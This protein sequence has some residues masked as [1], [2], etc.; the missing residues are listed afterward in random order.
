MKDNTISG[1][2]N[3]G[4]YSL[5]A[6]ETT[7]RNLSVAVARRQSGTG[8]CGEQESLVA[9]KRSNEA[10]RS[11]GGIHIDGSL[12]EIKHSGG[13]IYIS[14]RKS[15]G[16]L[17]HLTGLIPMI[18]DLLSAEGIA[19][20]SLDA[21]AVSSGPG[22]FT[23]IR[24]GVSATRALAQVLGL[25][26]IK[27]PTL[28]TFVYSFDGAPLVCPVFDARRSQV[29]AG[30]FR[31][32]LGGTSIE[33]I[34]PGGVFPPNEYFGRLE[35]K[36][37]DLGEDLIFCGD[38]ISVYDE[39]VRAAHGIVTNELQSARAVAGWAM[40]FGEVMNFSELEPIYM[41]KAEAQRKLEERLGLSERADV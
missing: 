29:Y 7:G 22:S 11:G 4:N 3:K 39:Y 9:G 27:V 1:I 23:G 35:I 6:I 12:N 14:E 2:V 10:K 28:E 40:A 26:V 20:S 13:G 18:Q 21:I 16:E 8:S 30:A 25:P 34:I 37:R 38:G 5:L 31:L 19:L 15:P 32:A 33:R 17:N 41:R 24:I 36:A